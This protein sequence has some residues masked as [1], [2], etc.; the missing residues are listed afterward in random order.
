MELALE[1]VRDEESLKAYLDGLSENQR[2]VIGLRVASNAALRMLPMAA[3]DLLTANWARERDFTPVALFGACLI[4][5]VAAAS[6]A[7]EIA[8]A[9]AY[10]AARA[11]TAAAPAPAIAAAAAPA[12]NAAAALAAARAVAA[13][14]AD[15]AFAAAALDLWPLVRRDL[16][17]ET[18][19]V[20]PE[21]TPQAMAD[22]WAEAVAAMRADKAEWSFWIAWYERVLAGKNWHPEEMV[23]ILNGITAKDWDKGPDH[24]NPMFDK[25]LALY[26]AE[27]DDAEAT[28]LSKAYPVDF[29]FDAL[30]R[31]MRM[32]GI[33]DN[34]RHLREP[35]VVQ[36]FVDDTDELKDGFQDFI[37]YAGDLAGAGNQAG[38]L[39]RASTKLLDELRRADE[40]VHIR[41]G[42]IV[43]LADDLE[44]FSK[45]EVAR[46]DLGPVLSQRLDDR[47]D[48]LKDV[49]RRHFGPSYLTL[50]PLAGLNFDQ[51]DQETVLAGFDAAIGAVARLP[52]DDLVALDPEGLAILRDMLDELRSYRAAIAEASTDEFREMLESRFA[53]RSG[54][55]GLTLTRLYDKSAT[56]LGTASTKADIAIR[57]H[58]RFNGLKDIWDAV[59]DVWP[60][61]AP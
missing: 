44:A 18:A 26:Q 59:R 40:A 5:R 30:R 3:R 23:P 20:W 48:T 11:A 9:A 36:A 60:G 6:P 57:T 55:A 37:D 61:D 10:A 4:S 47:I 38:V 39:R 49:C 21:G 58:K 32:V 54:A 25:V 7:R 33:D 43:Q 29:T 28:P 1:D 16:A 31:V 12:A 15:A 13:A 56:A 14:A 17:E 50:A 34:L 42:R 24:I 41:A 2:R 8:V 27:D 46:A 19:Q 45:Q 22:I 52:T 51:I 35:E 53:Q